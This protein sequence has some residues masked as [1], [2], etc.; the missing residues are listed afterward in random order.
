MQHLINGLVTARVTDN[1]DPQ[2]QGRVEVEFTALGSEAPRRWCP[3]ASVAAGDDSG[4]FFM[5]EIEDE[6]LVAFEN[7]DFDHAFIVGYPWNPVQ[8]PP[9]SQPEER[10]IRSRSGHTIR[11]IDGGGT[12][13]NFGALV[14][15]DRHGNAITMGNGVMT[16]N[17]TGHLNINALSVNIMG[18]PVNP[19]GGEI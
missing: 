5:P 2:G 12:G 17:A 11:F 10:M 7:G 15:E 18:R 9:S 6:V 4:V 8:M 1:R 14:V 3:V 16:I 19:L 13:G